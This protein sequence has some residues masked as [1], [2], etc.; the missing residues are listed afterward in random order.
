[1]KANLVIDPRVVLSAILMLSALF[2]AANKMTYTMWGF[3]LIT[4]LIGPFTWDDEG[5]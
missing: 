2:M 3:F 4:M 1:M 5:S